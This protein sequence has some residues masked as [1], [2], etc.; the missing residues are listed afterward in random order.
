MFL[1]F[2]FCA[3]VSQF[4]RFKMQVKVLSCKC[5]KP[6]NT[7]ARKIKFPFYL[8]HPLCAA[9]KIVVI[10]NLVF[11]FQAGVDRYTYHPSIN[12]HTVFAV[13][14]QD[15]ASGSIACT[16]LKCIYILGQKQN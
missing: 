11:P 2:A 6:N 13:L 7:N 10:F 5:Q 12:H 14:Q 1:K 16:L 8:V 9:I 15:I 3:N 4:H